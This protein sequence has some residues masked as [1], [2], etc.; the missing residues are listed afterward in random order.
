MEPTSNLSFVIAA[1]AV[2]WVGVVGYLLRLRTLLNRSRAAL[3]AAQAAAG[4][5]T[6]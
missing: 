6:P 3:T 1:Y 4:R 5:N 2:L